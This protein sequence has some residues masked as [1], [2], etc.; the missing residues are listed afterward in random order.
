MAMS[1]ADDLVLETLAGDGFDAL[2]LLAVGP[3]PIADWQRVVHFSE[4]VAVGSG[5]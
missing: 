2:S 3:G 5:I 4:A 1:C